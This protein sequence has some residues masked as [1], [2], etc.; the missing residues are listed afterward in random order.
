MTERI[1]FHVLGTRHDSGNT[2]MNKIAAVIL[3]G[4]TPSVRLVNCRALGQQF[5]KWPQDPW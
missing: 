3:M 5:S 1:H 2:K 4:S